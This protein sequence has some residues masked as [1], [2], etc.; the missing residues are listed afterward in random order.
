MYFL[1]RKKKMTTPTAEVLYLDEHLHAHANKGYAV[2]NPLNKP[3]EKLPFIF[4]FNN[5]GSPGWYHAQLIAEDGT[6]LGS[7]LC[8][9][10]GYMPHDLGILEGTRSDRHESFKKHYPKGY[11]M[12]FV[13]HDYPLLLKA[14]ELYGSIEKE[15]END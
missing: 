3:K 8:S 13:P 10:P 4:G 1:K 9:N 2:Y 7:H 5:G 15:K 12:D 11:Q 14:I 6:P